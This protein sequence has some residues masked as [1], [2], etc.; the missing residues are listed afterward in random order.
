MLKHFANVAY[1]VWVRFFNRALFRGTHS[2]GALR[3]DQPYRR[4]APASKGYNLP[5]RPEPF[6]PWNRRSVCELQ[7]R[8]AHF[9]VHNYRAERSRM[10][11]QVTPPSALANSETSIART[12]NPNW[13][14]NPAVCGWPA[15]TQT[16]VPTIDMLA[17]H[18][19]VRGTHATSNSR[20]ACMSSHSGFTSNRSSG[21][22]VQAVL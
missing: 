6:R 14:I 7:I 20:N 13:R 18:G 10:L 15:A 2:S 22:A 5:G 3:S 8:R 16:R 17:A 9:C 19:S 4:P 12:S 21:N 1:F 11:R